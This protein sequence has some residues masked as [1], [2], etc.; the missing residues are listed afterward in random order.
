MAMGMVHADGEYAP[1]AVSQRIDHD[2][3]ESRQADQQDEEEGDHRDQARAVADLGAGDVGQRFA[4]MTHGSDEH[5]EVVDAAGEHGANEDP[6]EAG[7]ETE[8]RRQSGSD[9][10]PSAGDGGKVMAKQ[11][12]LGRRNVVMAVFVDMGRRDAAVVEYQNFGGQE[13]AV[14]A[15]GQREHT[16]GPQHDGKRIQGD[17]LRASSSGPADRWALPLEPYGKIAWRTALGEE[18]D[19]KDESGAPA[20]PQKSG[21]GSQRAPDRFHL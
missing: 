19:V 16:Q 14:V 18:G 3:A 21:G 10:R 5:G 1:G 4:L 11:Y 7:G 2:D 15:I 13:G 20:E 8:L 9:Q 6:E 17:L 12:P